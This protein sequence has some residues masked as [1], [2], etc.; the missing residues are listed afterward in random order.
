MGMLDKLPPEKRAVAEK[1]IAAAQRHGVPVDVALGM[2]MQESGFDQ[3]KKS[4]TG[5]VGVM[6]V[7]R[8]LA[9]EYKIDPKN[10]DQNIDTGV[11]F[12][13]SLLNKHGNVEDALVAYHDGPNSAYFKG[14]QM[15]PAAANHITKVKGYAGTMAKE[16]NAAPTSFSTDIEEI[17]PVELMAEEAAVQGGRR[18]RDIG[19]VSA[20]L[21][22]AGI[23]YGIG[24]SREMSKHQK[25]MTLSAQRLAL[26]QQKAEQEALD[27]AAEAKKTRQFGSGTENWKNV[28]FG[29]PIAR[30]IVNPLD[31]PSAA[32]QGQAAVARHER[33][34]Q[35]FPTQIPAG[36][37][38]LLTIPVT[39]GGKTQV[40]MPTPEAPAAPAPQARPTG[41]QPAMGVLKAP[42]RIST[43]ITSGFGGLTAAQLYD[44]WKNI[45][46]GNYPEAALSGM[47]SLA[48]AIGT[49]STNPKVRALSG[50]VSGLGL[51]GEDIANYFKEPQQQPVEQK[52]EGGLTGLRNMAPHTGL[53]PYGARHSGEGVKGSG[54][55]GLQP[56]AEG[57][58]SEISAEDDEGEH[59]LMVPTLSREELDHLLN[60]G[61]PTEEIYRKAAQHAALRRGQGKSPFA[62]ATGLKYPV[63]HMA[64][65][66]ALKKLAQ[67]GL[68][69]AAN[70]FVPRATRELK[71]SEALG[72]H[73]GKWLNVTQADRM[74]STEGDLGGPG[75]SKFQLEHPEYAKA[76]AAWGVGNQ[77]TATRIINV[78]K[79]F[80]EGKSIWTPLLGHEEQHRS[81]QRTYDRL[82]AEFNRAVSEGKLP[83][84]IREAMNK[85]LMNWKDY[86]GMFPEG[87]DVANPEH[88]AGHG[89]TFDRRAA[90]S[91]VLGGKGIGG[92]KAQVF[93]YPGIM[94][95][96]TDPMTA[97]APTHSIGTRLFTL[98]NESA[99]RPDLHSAFPHI[100]TG[101]D[102]GVAYKP[103]PK[104]LALH[105]WMGAVRD[106]TG[107]EPGYY[108]F[109][110]GVKKGGVGLPAQH[111]N[112]DYL[113]RLQK[114]G[115]KK[116]GLV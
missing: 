103:V 32:R 23:G 65:G 105:D 97:G 27:K 75:F 76:K 16:T 7:S 112:E 78:N 68:E 84:D 94:Q 50:L 43:G 31:K 46:E 22:G 66:G 8:R 88:L 73:E 104:E 4:G 77:P 113:T 54:Y 90:I 92:R 48:S 83:P 38:S 106:F 93:D 108:D 28:E 39:L 17:A 12:M 11:R 111:I 101:E 82:T 89:S 42:G 57:Y 49:A 61:E 69:W 36:E 1:V 56:G 100:L 35:I 74:R 20:G 13:K 18:P 72:E 44:A 30:Q 33:A 40:P 115:Y 116:G 55:F 21:G 99:H 26:Q 62:D 70:K 71:A 5:P 58:S 80:P 85:R 87:F 52:A 107:R 59:P 51:F 34:S 67:E 47:G 25:E 79:R 98:N 6:Q 14:G 19:D 3:S 86:A 37:G 109:T 110:M 95:E 29:E 53:A 15:S 9:K 81:N 60:G 41:Q 63:P 114:A 64:G 10:I 45:Q 2:A 102:L 91:D 96:M 24:K